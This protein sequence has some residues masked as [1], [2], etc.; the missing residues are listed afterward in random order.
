MPRDYMYT[1]EGFD[2]DLSIV[3]DYPDN[4]TDLP[5]ITSSSY[6]GTGSRKPSDASNPSDMPPYRGRGMSFELF[7]FS[8]SSDPSTDL[9]SEALNGGR[10]RGDSIIFDPISFSDGGIHEETALLKTRQH[11]SSIVLDDCEE[12]N[13]LNTAGFAEAPM[14]QQQN[15]SS[16]APNGHGHGHGHP[17]LYSL[18]ANHTIPNPVSIRPPAHANYSARSK[19]PIGRN[20]KV[21]SR[22]TPTYHHAKSLQVQ[23]KIENARR[24]N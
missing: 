2:F 15:Q 3:T 13:L 11:R 19:A 21:P 22:V 12:I 16:S 20:T 7:A 5:P 10:P 23:Y 17:A 6:T 24:Q 4:S 14:M 8:M 1:A 9:R 18:D